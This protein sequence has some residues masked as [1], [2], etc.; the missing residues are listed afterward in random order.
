MITVII[1]AHVLGF[2]SSIYAVMETRTAQGAV[3]WAVTLNAVPYVAV[4]AYWILGRKPFRGLCHSAAG[5]RPRDPAHRQSSGR[6]SRPQCD[7]T[8]P[9][10]PPTAGQ[11]RTSQRSPICAVT[12]SNYW[13]TAT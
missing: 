5:G 4:P 7:P 8:G 6:E 9:E 10:I 11:G 13:W 12:R 3:A 2:I 1:V